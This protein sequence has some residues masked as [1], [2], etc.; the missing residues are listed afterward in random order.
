MSLAYGSDNN[1]A[2]KGDRESLNGRPSVLNP[3][4]RRSSSTASVKGF[5]GMLSRASSIAEDTGTDVSFPNNN[6]I[7]MI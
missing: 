4:F 3:S 2:L 1:G 7:I 5:S 6:A